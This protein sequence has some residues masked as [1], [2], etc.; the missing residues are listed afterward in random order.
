MES[1]RVLIF[2]TLVATITLNI[3]LFY[4][5]LSWLAMLHRHQTF[6]AT[7]GAAVCKAV[8]SWSNDKDATTRDFI[9]T[10]EEEADN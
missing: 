7:D 10:Q 4:P 8:G 2:L 9:R 1:V 3:R 6:S 5:C